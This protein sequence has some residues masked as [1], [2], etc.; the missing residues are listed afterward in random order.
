MSNITF[1]TQPLASQ[2]MPHPF[3]YLLCRHSAKKQE[4]Q[5][6]WTPHFFELLTLRNQLTFNFLSAEEHLGQKPG[7]RSGCQEMTKPR[8]FESPLMVTSVVLGLATTVR[9]DLMVA[10]SGAFAAEVFHLSL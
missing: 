5:I 1:A 9:A 4:K 8:R 10:L 6:Q 7:Y 2:A 3:V